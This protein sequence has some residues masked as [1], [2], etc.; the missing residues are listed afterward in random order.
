MMG[1]STYFDTADRTV[2]GKQFSQTVFGRIRRESS[3]VHVGRQGVVRIV[4]TVARQRR[5]TVLSS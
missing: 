2:L 4:V 5:R 3:N 1:G